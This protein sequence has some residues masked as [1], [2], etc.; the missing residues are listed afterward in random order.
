[1]DTLQAQYPPSI[2]H[3]LGILLS[4][5]KSREPPQQCGTGP[6]WAGGPAEEPPGAGARTRGHQAA[7]EPSWL[8]LRPRPLQPP[9]ASLPVPLDFPLSLRAS[10]GPT[11]HGRMWPKGARVPRQGIYLWDSQED[12]TLASLFPAPPA[13]AGTAGDCRRVQKLCPGPQA[14]AVQQRQ[15]AVMQAWAVLQR[16]VE[17]RR[18]QLERA[19]LLARFRTA[20]RAPAPW[21]VCMRM[22]VC[23]TTHGH[24]CMR[25]SSSGGR[26]STNSG[27]R[28]RAHG[29]QSGW[30]GAEHMGIAVTP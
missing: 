5:G 17:Q 2:P 15:Q 9:Q 18:A 20:V 6:A 12:V 3:L 4:S 27:G 19:R 25:P 14:H 29:G 7:G 11:V 16:R 10:H 22:C 24:A 28:A 30:S 21:V 8:P 1:M 13:A 26:T 23:C